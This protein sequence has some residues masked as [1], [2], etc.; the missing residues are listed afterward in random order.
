M[1]RVLPSRK[2]SVLI[3]HALIAILATGV[4][5]AMSAAGVSVADEQVGSD[6]EGS[7]GSTATD[8]TFI[9]KAWRARQERVRSVRFRWKPDRSGVN[10]WSTYQ[11]AWASP[12][13]GAAPLPEETLLIIGE[14]FNDQTVRWYYRTDREY[15]GF[16]GSSDDPEYYFPLDTP[17]NRT[18]LMSFLQAL[19]D[20]LGRPGDQ[21]RSPRRFTRSFDGNLFRE[22]FSEEGAVR[23]EAAISTSSGS[24]WPEDL[25]YRP[26]LLAFRPLSPMTPAIDPDR[27]RLEKGESYV[28]GFN[29]R[30]LSETGE[31]GV[32]RSFWIDPQRDCVVV[33]QVEEHDGQPAA[34]LDITYEQDP[35]SGWRPSAWTCL[36]MKGA[37][38]VEGYP[39]RDEVFQFLTVNVT[40]FAINADISEEAVEITFPSGTIVN[41]AVREQ[42]YSVGPNGQFEPL[43]RDDLFAIRDA[44]AGRFWQRISIRGW[45]LIVGVGLIATGVGL[46]IRRSRTQRRAAPE[47][48][49]T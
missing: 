22:F 4:C 3:G 37:A 25:T 9:M 30:L 10:R 36:L 7:R 26:L 47:G 33:R 24:R 1:L 23:P 44:G 46:K 6:G 32:V 14:K 40:D 8:F 31:N 5:M 15:S 2:S 18:A 45:M 49:G 17:S 20:Q 16:N 12:R 34:Q 35:E 13:K 43:T 41:D 42:H 27:C 28:N 19:G 38:S 39:G 11:T 21:F 29:C 48:V